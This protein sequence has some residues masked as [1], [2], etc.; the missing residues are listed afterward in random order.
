MAFS[1]G[2]DVA[3]CQEYPKYGVPADIIAT[4]AKLA[5]EWTA[6]VNRRLPVD[7][8]VDVDTCCR[9]TITLRKRGEQNGG[10][11]KLRGGHGPGKGAKNGHPRRRSNR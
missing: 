8:Q 9:R 11:P 2:L 7:Q 3:L 4:D 6:R 10:L 5:A 1:L